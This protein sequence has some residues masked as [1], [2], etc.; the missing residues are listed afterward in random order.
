MS[1]TERFDKLDDAI[2]RLAVVA[3]DLSKMLAVHEHRIAHQEKTSEN[4]VSSMEKRR[5]E[6][7]AVFKEFRE[8]LKQE[9]ESLRQNSTKQHDEQNVKIEAIQK[10]LWAAMGAATLA[11]WVI[12]IVINK[13]L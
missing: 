13:F 2:Q 9:I 3:S 7:D 4:I 8:S 6:V 5:A 10:T 12:P 11:G 1:E